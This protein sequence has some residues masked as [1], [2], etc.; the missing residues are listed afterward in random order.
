MILSRWLVVQ[1]SS[2]KSLDLEAGVD[3]NTNPQGHLLYAFEFSSDSILAALTVEH[4]CNLSATVFTE[5]VSQSGY[6]DH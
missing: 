1:G 2:V 5:V 6:H 4:I 3:D